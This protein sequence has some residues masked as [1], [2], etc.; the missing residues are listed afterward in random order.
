MNF[1]KYFHFWLY[2]KE[3]SVLQ[4]QKKVFLAH[5]VL[6][7]ILTTFIVLGKTSCFLN[8]FKDP[9]LVTTNEF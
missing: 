8:A 6:R 4:E 2:R 7:S 1:L 9:G 5:Q 3:V